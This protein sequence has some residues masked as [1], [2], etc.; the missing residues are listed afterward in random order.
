MVPYQST[1]VGLLMSIVAT[2]CPPAEIMNA[3]NSVPSA[4]LT[5]RSWARP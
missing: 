5:N 3:S 2:I 1:A 4:I